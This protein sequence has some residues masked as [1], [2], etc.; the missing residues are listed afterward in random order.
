MLQQHSSHTLPADIIYEAAQK[1][2][3]TSRFSIFP[4][5]GHPHKP[6]VPVSTIAFTRKLAY[7]ER[8]TFPAPLPDHVTG[9]SGGSN[10]IMGTVLV[11]TCNSIGQREIVSLNR[12]GIITPMESDGRNQGDMYV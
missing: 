1:Q 8:Q 10:L 4:V 12:R 5:P 11:N 6:I 2:R 9:R 3:L 7:P